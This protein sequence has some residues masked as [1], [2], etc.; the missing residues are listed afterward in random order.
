MTLRDLLDHFTGFESIPDIR[1]TPEFLD[2][3]EHLPKNPGIYVTILRDY[4]S[5]LG[6]DLSR[7]YEEFLETTERLEDVLRELYFL[8]YRTFEALLEECE[9]ALNNS[10]SEVGM[11]ALA[12]ILSKLPPKG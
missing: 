3:S 10:D 5:G 7:V 1:G 2:I 6:G 9:F 11:T 4:L 8:D 12:A